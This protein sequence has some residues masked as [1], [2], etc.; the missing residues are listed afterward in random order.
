MT[1]ND[2]GLL[3]RASY[4]CSSCHDKE[5]QLG[6][7]QREIVKVL[8]NS[9][10]TNDKLELA[11]STLAE[12]NE[13]LKKV[14]VEANNLK[15]EV[16]TKKEQLKQ[17]NTNLESTKSKLEKCTKEN[18]A[19]R[20]NF[21]NKIINLET[22]NRNLKKQID[23][24]KTLKAN[25]RKKLQTKA[26]QTD[27]N[28]SLETKTVESQTSA[29]EVKDNSTETLLTILDLDS[30]IEQ[31]FSGFCKEMLKQLGKTNLEKSHLRLLVYTGDE[32]DVV[33]TSEY[34]DDY[35]KALEIMIEHETEDIDDNEFT[36]DD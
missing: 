32:D 8:V 22:Q 23:D 31:L 26:I 36:E 1:E 25:S 34:Y 16:K 19:C 33:A 7:I 35:A 6:D 20:D 5:K 30:E 3:S 12:T 13:K 10:E 17:K 14:Q 27:G 28:N 4:L 9:N 15:D 29:V 24:M 11:K 18:E 2:S 21:K